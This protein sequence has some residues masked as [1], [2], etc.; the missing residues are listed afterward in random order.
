MKPVFVRGFNNYDAMAASNDVALHC[1]DKSLTQQSFAEEVDIN[2][3]VRRFGLG[4]EPPLNT[5]MPLN[6]DFEGVFDFQ[7]AMNVIVAAREAFDAQPAEVRARF[8]NNPAEFVDFCSDDENYEEARRL[9]LVDPERERARAAAAA[10]AV[11]A[12]REAAVKSAL[13]AD[14]ASR[15]AEGAPK[16]GKHS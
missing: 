10:A 4:Y 11:A 3:I 8:H 1:R 12:E 5:R 16:G 15:G 14:R 2:T 13:E 6:G 7:S 9:G